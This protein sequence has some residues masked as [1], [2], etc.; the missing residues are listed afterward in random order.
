M[1]FK[2]GLFYTCY[3]EVAMVFVKNEKVYKGYC[4]SHRRFKFKEAFKG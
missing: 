3:N 1:L 2:Q 4:L